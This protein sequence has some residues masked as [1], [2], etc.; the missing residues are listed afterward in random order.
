[1]YKD[2]VEHQYPYDMSDCETFTHSTVDKKAIGKMKDECDGRPIDGYF[3]PKMNSILEVDDK[4]IKKDKGGKS[5]EK[6]VVQQHKR[7]RQYME[8]LFVRKTFCQGMDMLWSE[9][10]R[11][12]WR[13]STKCH[14]PPST[15]SA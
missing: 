4:N 2:R 8:A 6:N 3:S 9:R 12:Y 10:R 7:N 14:L 15:A 11:I 5:C 13:T 1:M